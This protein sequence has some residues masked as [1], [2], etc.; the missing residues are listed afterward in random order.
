[1]RAGS[2][3]RVS[4]RKQKIQCTIEMQRDAISEW[5]ASQRPPVVIPKELTFE[6]EARSGKVPL[7]RRPGG[8]ALLEAIHAGKIDTLVVFDLSRLSRDVGD[9]HAVRKEIV[10]KLGIHIV[11]IRTG[12]VSDGTSESEFRDGLDNLVDANEVAKILE[13]TTRGRK[14]VLAQGYWPGGIPPFGFRSER[15]TTEE[16]SKRTRLVLETKPIPGNPEL[17]EV[18]VVRI[19]YGKLADGWS[20]QNVAD[21]L[22][23]LGIPAHVVTEGRKK[24][25]I[26]RYWRASRIV[27][28]ARN[29]IYKGEFAYGKRHNVTEDGVRQHL[30]K[31]DRAKQII[32]R[33]PFIVSNELW[34]RAFDSL[35]SHQLEQMSHSKHQYLLRKLITCGECGR[36]YSGGG[37]AM[38]RCVGRSQVREREAALGGNR[39]SVKHGIR[40]GQVEPAIWEKA[41][42]FIAHPM[43]LLEELERNLATTDDEATVKQEIIRIEVVLARNREVDRNN[44]RNLNEGALTRQDFQLERERLHRQRADLE[45]ELATLQ[46]QAQAKRTR[47]QSLQSTHEMLTSLRDFAVD[48]DPPFEAKRKIIEQLVESITVFPEGQGHRLE[49]T[50]KFQSGRDRFEDWTAEPSTQSAT[51]WGR[52]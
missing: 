48:S 26:A 39:C 9:G 38:Y 37:R 51:S 24:L 7:H 41:A 20:A 33:V 2:Y 35:R 14:T 10:R 40:M 46:H 19:I 6:D 52:S 28:L 15:Q 23:R 12:R 47:K 43:L 27:H 5:R 49:V 13:R 31:N 34:Q 8:K 42:S 29:A 22:N 3:S 30:R 44:V 21:Y 32:Q 4:G 36:H 50:W 1:M 25:G 11:S 18:K 17:T 16:G 45:A